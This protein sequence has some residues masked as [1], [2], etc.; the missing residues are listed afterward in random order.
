MVII[1]ILNTIIANKLTIMVR[2]A[3]E[4]GQVSTVGDQHG[5]FNMPMEPGRVQA[6]RHGVRV[7]R[8]YP[9]G[10]WE[11]L[12]IRSQRQTESP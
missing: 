5:T 11:G 1:S 7:L 6:L 9:L 8:M 3:A 10:L 2:Q 12:T 4:L